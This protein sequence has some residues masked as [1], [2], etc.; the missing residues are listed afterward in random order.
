MTKLYSDGVKADYRG[1]PLD[2]EAPLLGVHLIEREHVDNNGKPFSDYAYLLESQAAERLVESI[3]GKVN[4][5]C[6][7]ADF[8]LDNVQYPALML[9][10]RSNTGMNS[11]LDNVRFQFGKAVDEMLVKIKV[12]NGHHQNN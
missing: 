11:H 2:W 12:H 4:W 10:S 6:F 5:N 3:M 1:I 8:R 7:T 9:F